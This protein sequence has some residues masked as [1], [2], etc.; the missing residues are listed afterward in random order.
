M[1]P[2]PAPACR[3]LQSMSARRAAKQNIGY[4]R[5]AQSARELRSDDG[6][7]FDTYFS[8]RFCLKVCSSVRAEGV[9]AR[10]TPEDSTQVYQRLV[11]A[12]ELSHGFCLKGYARKSL[13]VAERARC[14]RRGQSWNGHARE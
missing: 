4:R 2:S 10:S 11:P 8:G 5:G 9:R 12:E 6:K 1:L 3:A 7:T 14:A 13:S